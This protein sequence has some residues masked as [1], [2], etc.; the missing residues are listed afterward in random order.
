MATT[1]TRQRTTGYAKTSR[2]YTYTN[3]GQSSVTTVSYPGYTGGIESVSDN[4]NVGFRQARDQGCVVLS[5]LVL[6]RSSRSFTPGNQSAGSSS[7]WTGVMSGDMMSMLQY[8]PANQA[9]MSVST[10]STNA[11]FLKAMAK[12]NRADILMGENL[13]EIGQI[14]SMIR[15]PFKTSL[16]LLGK[17]SK[18]RKLRLGKTTASAFKACS[19]AWLEYRYGWKPILLDC[20]KIIEAT[21]KK[22]ES[23]E[24]R[25][26]VAR[27]G[28]SV[29]NKGSGSW[30][31]RINIGGY[32]A[33]EGS[34]SWSVST[35]VSVGIVYDVKNRTSSDDLMKL[36]GMRPSDLIP[37]MWELVPYSF[38][39]DWFSNVGDWL[40]AITPDPFVN[41][42][43]NWMTSVTETLSERQGTST[44]P[45]G[46][47]TESFWTGS[48][49]SETITSLNVNRTV[50]QK[51]TLT[52]ELTWKPLSVLHQVDA[53]SLMNQRIS[54]TLKSF[55]H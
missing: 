11:L 50:N 42:R 47:S 53:L 21:H 16:K 15:S 54:Q 5:D 18:Y 10:I 6:F 40:Q 28:E 45:S 37:T 20:Q 49:G 13:A 30:P 7:G 35:R 12:M 34:S 41:P 4:N 31:C 19:D 22:R 29:S 27:A 24:K 52:P 38:V 55:K 3:P 17:M 44:L 33:S 2:T 8:G 9:N 46:Y 36:L 39:V 26:L 1:R 14:L 32:R 48:Y 43:G 25:R 51:I 23:K